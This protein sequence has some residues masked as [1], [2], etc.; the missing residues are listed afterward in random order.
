MPLSSGDNLGPYE[1]LS[2]IGAGGMG[3][4]YKARDTRLDRLVAI[5]TSKKSICSA[6]LWTEARNA[7]SH[8]ARQIPWPRCPSLPT[9][10]PRMAVSWSGLCGPI[11]ISILPAWSTPTPG[12]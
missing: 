6:S 11:C 8:S 2:P 4:V 1:I 7:K 3:E 5:K 9:R 10:Y 12:G